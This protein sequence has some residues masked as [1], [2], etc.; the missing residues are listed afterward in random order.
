MVTI[1]ASN[2]NSITGDDVNSVKSHVLEVSPL[3][4]LAVTTAEKGKIGNTKPKIQLSLETKILSM[5]NSLEEKTNDI[6]K[7]MHAL[8]ERVMCISAKLESTESNT[9]LF[10]RNREHLN[11]IIIDDVLNK[12]N[13]QAEFTPSVINYQAYNSNSLDRKVTHNDVAMVA[14]NAI[15]QSVENVLEEYPNSNLHLSTTDISSHHAKK[16]YT[17]TELKEKYY[18]DNQKETI[19]AK[20]M[21]WA[22]RVEELE[23]YKKSNGNCDVPQSHETGLGIWVSAQ[24]S[25]YKR[26]VAGKSSSL[27]AP[28]KTLLEKIG[29]TWSLRKRSTWEERFSELKTYFQTYGTCDVPNSRKHLWSWCHNQRQAYK[30]AQE[31]RPAPLLAE[32]VALMETLGFRWNH[33]SDPSVNFVETTERIPTNTCTIQTPLHVQSMFPEGQGRHTDLYLASNYN[34]SQ[35]EASNQIQHQV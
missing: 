18:D 24:R 5:L 2:D 8:E 35:L 21:S 30:R 31:G 9:A 10:E 22:E 16:G 4:M 20:R 28:R 12:R 17:T 26:L 11:S 29:I 13:D 27:A 33:R 19:V 7:I 23:F 6:S 25:Q 15:P 3:E 34:H 14:D 1:V 32:R